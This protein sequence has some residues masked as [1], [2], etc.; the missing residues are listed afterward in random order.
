MVHTTRITLRLRTGLRAFLES[1]AGEHTVPGPDGRPLS[2]SEILRQAVSDILRQDLDLEVLQYLL[3]REK[4]L[5]AHGGGTTAESHAF[6]T[7][8]WTT[9]T[10][11]L[12]AI[13]LRESV[14]CPLLW[15]NRTEILRAALWTISWRI[16][17]FHQEIEQWHAHPSPPTYSEIRTISTDG[18]ILRLDPRHP[19]NMGRERE[20][21]SRPRQCI[22]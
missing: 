7:L 20:A 15:H 5:L 16:T 1:A 11:C 4:T 19:L 22:D 17:P 18:R 8:P 3:D 9:F 21:F 12:I 2:A 10:A 14:S 13:T 6:A